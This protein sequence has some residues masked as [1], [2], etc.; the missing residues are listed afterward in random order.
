MTQADKWLAR[1]YPETAEDCYARVGQDIL[2]L[3]QHSLK[4]WRGLRPKAL[5]GYW[6]KVRK[7]VVLCSTGSVLDINSDSCALCWAF[8]DEHC[9]DCPLLELRDGVRCSASEH[10]NDTSPYM[11]LLED[12]DPE[13]MI[14]LL[15]RAVRREKRRKP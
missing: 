15:E 4:K 1:Y 5:E 14:K 10:T 2:A 8:R 9:W 6:L 3:L 11:I 12:N 13:P 7:A